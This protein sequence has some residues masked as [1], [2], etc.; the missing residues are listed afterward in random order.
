MV[1]LNSLE[2][3]KFWA[4]PGI[5]PGTSR[6]RSENHT[7]R[8]T[9]QAA[10]LTSSK[11]DDIV[12]LSRSRPYKWSFPLNIMST[13]WGVEKN[14]LSIMQIMPVE[15]IEQANMWFW[16][17]NGIIDLNEKVGTCHFFQSFFVWSTQSFRNG[18]SN[19][20]QA[21]LAICATD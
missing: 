4:C 18:L 17:A 8:P 21:E 7:P 14:G 15:L 19:S 2:M 10:L 1:L 11:S 9:S 16:K 3:L 20:I 13:L 12:G 6:T 5:E